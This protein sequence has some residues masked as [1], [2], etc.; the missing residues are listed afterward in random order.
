MG[1]H[2]VKKT[3]RILQDEG[4]VEF[5]KKFINFI[6]YN[7]KK[8]MRT[9]TF[10]RGIIFLFNTKKNKVVNK[11]R[12]DAPAAPYKT[13]NVKITD[14]EYRLEN[15]KNPTCVGLGKIKSGSWDSDKHKKRVV[16][17]PKVRS[18]I[19]RFGEN[20]DWHEIKKYNCEYVNGQLDEL[21]HDI[22]N[23]GYVPNHPQKRIEGPNHSPPR[24]QLSILVTIDRNGTICQL[25]GSHRFGMTYVLDLE[26]PVHVVCRHKKWQEFRDD[27]YNNGFPTNCEELRDHPDLQDV[28]E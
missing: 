15:I 2:L 14:I 25:D 22:K 4:A 20:K 10:I 5:V 8:K 17:H 9:L 19:Q 23:N 26:I 28:I 1:I 12:Y 6:T 3:F 13:I 27:I 18:M 16:E 7:F 24:D 21:F 11:I